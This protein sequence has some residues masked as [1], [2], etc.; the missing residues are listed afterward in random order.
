MIMKL[1]ALMG[2]ILGIF[3]NIKLNFES[4]LCKKAAQK[5]NALARLKTALHQIKETYFLILS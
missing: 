2:K 1:L 3:L 4:S 5:I